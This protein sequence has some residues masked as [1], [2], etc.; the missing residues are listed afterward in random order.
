MQ[1][2]AQGNY[3]YHPIES[4]CAFIVMSSQ[5]YSSPSILGL[6]IAFAIRRPNILHIPTAQIGRPLMFAQFPLPPSNASITG[7]GLHDLRGNPSIVAAHAIQGRFHF[8]TGSVHGVAIKRSGPL[9]G[10]LVSRIN[11][12]SVIVLKD[13]LRRVARKF[14]HALQAGILFRSVVVADGVHQQGRN[15]FGWKVGPRR[16]SARV[17]NGLAVQDFF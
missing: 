12:I 1:L 11:K 14:P 4:V 8:P 2:N 10:R 17:G 7:H 5:H 16:S 9:G 13:V 3:R 15:I 6:K